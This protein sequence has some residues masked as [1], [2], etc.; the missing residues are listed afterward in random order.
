TRRLVADLQSTA[1]VTVTA[2]ASRQEERARWYAEQYGIKVG[3]SSYA[4][5]LERDD[6]DAVYIALPPAL[7]LEWAIAAAEAGKAVLCEKPVVTSL[8]DFLRLAEVCKQKEQR[9]LD[10]TGWLYHP[11]TAAIAERIE[12]G[13]IGQLRHV[14]TAVS[15]FEPF[16]TNDH[17]LNRSLGGGCLLDLGW[18]A[19][20][21]AV[22]SL[23]QPRQVY[24]TA[25]ERDG[26]LFR[27]TALL[28]FDQQWTATINCGYD[29]STRKWCEIAGDQGSIV[30]DDF[31]RPWP[32]KPARFWIHD[33]A[34]S[35]EQEQFQGHQEKAMIETF[36]GQ[37]PLTVF[38]R[39]AMLTQM[40][41]DAIAR[42]LSS[43]TAEPVVTGQRSSTDEGEAPPCA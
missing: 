39:Q 10:A 29:T 19:V 24:A 30:C 2:I 35:V 32:E 4:D 42:S 21:L 40:T 23:G 31:T 14:T 27:V 37:D 12:G 7:H 38:H 3:T 16:Q 15:F 11:R 22:W 33:R 25:I 36:V 6:V 18:Y 9:W 43:G 13:K 5:L 1:G 20:G 34:G 28:A 26:V 17:R 41:L 8:S